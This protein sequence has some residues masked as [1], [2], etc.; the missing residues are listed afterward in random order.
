MLS[1]ND[2]PIVLL[3]QDRELI[4]LLGLTESEYRQFLREAVKRSRVEPGKPVNF[5]DFG[6]VA[7]I[8]T[9]IGL[10][11]QVAAL[12]FK[13]K[14]SRPPDIRQTSDPGQNVVN[15]TE[16]APK[17]GFDSL[18]NV[19]EL[20]SAIPL[21]FA[22]RETIDGVT[23]GGVRVNTNL[24]WSQMLSLG[25]GQML[26]AVFLI[27]EATIGDV[28]PSQFAFGDNVMGAYDLAE[29]NAASSRVTFYVSKDGGRLTSA[30]RVAG[31][32]AA[33]DLGNAQNVG[34]EDVFSI[35]G[36]NGA[37]TTDFCYT[38]KPS[39]QTQFGVYQLIG[40]GFGFRVNPA[41][42]PAV[43]VKTEPKGDQGDIRL[44]CLQDG[45]SRAQRDKYN[46]KFSSRSGVTQLNG[47]PI[48]GVMSLVVGDTVTYVLD[49]ASD[50]NTQFIGV[51][52]GPNHKETC[53]DVAQAV[54]GRQRSWDDALTIGELYRLGSALLICESRSPAD[55]I[56]TSEA[57]QEPIG[58]GQTMSVVLRCVRAGTAVFNPTSGTANATQ[59]SHLFK[60]AVANFS[61]PR[62]AQIVELGLR[63]TLGIRISGLC[64]F[65]D[66]L[67]E[68]EI[69]GRACN[70]YNGRVYDSGESLDLS[71]YQ[72]GSFSGAEMRYSFFKISY[73][74]AGSNSGYTSLEPCFGVRS[75]TQQ[76]VYNYIRLQMPSMQ[77]WEYRLE[78]VTGWEI[79]N[80][81]ASGN[82]EILD[83][84]ITGTRSVGSGSG[85]ETVM[86]TYS[87]EPVARTADTFAI[88]A[89]RDK[90]LGVTLSD[91][92]DYADDWGKVAEAF[93]F[94][95][96]QTSARSPEHELVYVNLLAP[97]PNIPEYESL[98][99]VGVNLRSS[100]E[101]SQLNQLSVYIN[102]GI[103]SVHTFPEVY[104][105]LLKN[106]VFGVG[107]ILS[108][109]QIDNESF[110]ECAAWTRA[111]KYFFDGAIAQPI[112]L[113][114]WGSQ[115]AGFFLLDMVIKNGRFALQPAFYFN[116]P[117]PITN[118]YT[119]GNIID[120]SFEFAYADIEQ[121]TP[122]RISVKWRQEK[123]FDTETNKGLFPVVRE[124]TVCEVGT[125]K[126]APLESIDLSDFCTSENHAIDV[127]KYI[128]R[129]RR[130]YTHS[131]K[132]KTVPTQ[133]AVQVGRC[134]KL[135]LETVAYNQPNNGAIDKHGA[136]TTT[137]PLADGTYRVLL[138]DGKATQVI[139]ADLEI[140]D[141]RT[142]QYTSAVF[143]VK[144]TAN[145]VRTYKVQSVG[146]DEDGNVA[147]EA[148]YFPLNSN[149]YSLVAEGWD[150]SSNWV[151]EG[152]LGS[153]EVSGTAISP[154]NGVSLIGPNTLTVNEASTFTALVSGGAG[155]YSYS[156][157]G[158]GVTF[159]AA[160]AASTTVTATS[161]GNKTIT[162]A[163]TRGSTTLAVSKTVT[164]VVATSQGTIGTVTIT[165]DATAVV[166]SAKTYS[167]S[168]SGTVA[169][170]DCFYNWTTIP[171]TSTVASAGTATASITFEVAGTY[172]VICTI[173]S[174]YASDS[175]KT[176]TK[177]VT[178]T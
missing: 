167:A 166:N 21:V 48:S 40:N 103:G 130:L 37:W 91:T 137:E 154:F 10:L 117:E 29:A 97:N 50:A 46:T 12:F 57:D 55:E 105:I 133:A 176:Q 135:G 169:L 102:E 22:K 68:T 165:G 125:P 164:A 123:A 112:N 74:I 82:L 77:R 108:P 126:N 34:A 107:E 141:Q 33:N 127:G 25:G 31:R 61:L 131:V 98:A 153:S 76:A 60:T 44:R 174:P 106:S 158:S 168:R 4:E 143:C 38:F 51:Q 134:I 145:E 52:E 171:T 6:L 59:T 39:T 43:V 124:V 152:A 56:F 13:P 115:T 139:E 53:R 177:T 113:R 24:L 23:Y 111:R 93:V 129:G 87:G 178:V 128:C 69:D 132:F 144:Q 27:S 138:W 170:A 159:G 140:L 42:R 45:V 155:S 151:I 156:W 175:P 149:D 148:M 120:G 147:I 19:V 36:L 85:T 9:V 114:Q 163:V 66:S 62:A 162:C 49:S 122:S 54:S 15:R 84:R 100:T 118:L 101:A 83:S 88:A 172:S 173:S 47:T 75:L 142:T 11:L 160:S 72:S 5:I 28:D 150:V 64:N 136:V 73:R 63:S 92:R 20:G 119:A 65:R 16:Y 3:P 18:Q 67:S 94:E 86:I 30:D 157:S 2:R 35:A 99:T 79:R 8:F 90:A 14:T 161:A 121:R 104:S 78:P 26:R 89:T 7:L 41:L 95:E 109:E 32:L 1:P 116:Q 71:S 70:Y 58:G 110:T 146:Y 80:S 96:L 17:A 81:I